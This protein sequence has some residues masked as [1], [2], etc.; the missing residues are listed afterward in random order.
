[1]I[2]KSGACLKDTENCSSSVLTTRCLFTENT[3]LLISFREMLLFLTRITQNI[4]KFG[5][6]VG[7]INV[8]RII[9][10]G[11]SE[12]IRIFVKYNIT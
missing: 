3:F 9:H 12:I 8:A 7:V 2:L 4:K 11:C 6:D 5:Y 10:E 1:M